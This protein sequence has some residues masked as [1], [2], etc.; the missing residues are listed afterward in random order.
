M[1][2]QMV[3][4]PTPSAI[5]REYGMPI[6]VKLLRLG[7]D[8]RTKAR[9]FKRLQLFQRAQLCLKVVSPCGSFREGLPHEHAT[10]EQ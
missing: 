1:L 10:P 6:V 8:Y 2:P 4:T 7:N 5:M 9:I 3:K